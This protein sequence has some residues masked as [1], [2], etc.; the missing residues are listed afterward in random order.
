MQ[1]I[2]QKHI[3]QFLQD[4]SDFDFGEKQKIDLEQHMTPP[5]LAAQTLFHVYQN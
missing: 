4:I 3:E 2:K 5:L 1:S